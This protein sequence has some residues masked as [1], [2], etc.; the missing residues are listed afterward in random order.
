MEMLDVPMGRHFQLIEFICNLQ[1]GFVI[2]GDQQDRLSV[3]DPKLFKE[4]NH[5]LFQLR[6]QIAEGFIQDQEI[7]RV[8]KSPSQGNPLLL[9]A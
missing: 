3:A 6:I 1:G 8:Q 4:L 2:M 9:S 7:G 5:L